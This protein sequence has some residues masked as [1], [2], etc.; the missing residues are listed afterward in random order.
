MHLPA[1]DYA[2][3]V[4][5]LPHYSP[6]SLD[7]LGRVSAREQGTVSRTQCWEF[8]VRPKGRAQQ[9]PSFICP[10]ILAAVSSGRSGSLIGASK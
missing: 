6:P 7:G 9:P 1:Q 4:T 2:C 3:G 5:S 8:A 10:H